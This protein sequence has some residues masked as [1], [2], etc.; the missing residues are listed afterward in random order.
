MQYFC[1]TFLIYFLQQKAD[2]NLLFLLFKNVVF[3]THSLRLPYLLLVENSPK[4]I[5][6]LCKKVLTQAF[7]RA[8][9]VLAFE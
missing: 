9:L 3:F 6:N 5:K 1:S 7:W 8:I 2:F 4:I